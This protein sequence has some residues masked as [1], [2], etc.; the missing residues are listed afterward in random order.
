MADNGQLKRR[1]KKI[2]DQLQNQKNT[3]PEK[4]ALFNRI[5]IKQNQETVTEL[6][7]KDLESQARSQGVAPEQ[8][9]SNGT[10]DAGVD[11]GVSDLSEA[12]QY[13]SEPVQEDDEEEEQSSNIQDR[14]D[15]AQD[16][17]SNQRKRQSQKQQD[18]KLKQQKA[19]DKPKPKTAPKKP[20]VRPTPKPPVASRLSGISRFARGIATVG[21]GLVA[22]FSTPAGWVTLAIILV[23]LIVFGLLLA[24]GAGGK[25]K[26]ISSFGGSQFLPLDLSREEDKAILAQVQSLADPNQ[27][28]PVIEVVAPA[29]VDDLIQLQATDDGDEKYLLDRRIPQTLNYLANEGWNKI[30]IGLLKTNGPDF[31][32]RIDQRSNGNGEENTAYSA[33]GLGQAMGIVAIGKTSPGLTKCLGLDEPIP[34]QIAW[35]EM[36]SENYLRP[37]YEELQV[38]LTYLFEYGQRDWSIAGNSEGVR[39]FSTET[40]QYLNDVKG[41]LVELQTTFNANGSTNLNTVKYAQQAS[42]SLANVNIE[43]AVE[44]WKDLRQGMMMTYTMMRARNIRGWEGSTSNG[45]KLWKAAEAINNQR[46]LE[47][48]LLMM[49]TVLAQPERNGKPGFNGDIVPKQ[50][51]VWSP[52]DDI[53][54]GLPDTDVWPSG[55]T[56]ID[57]GGVGYSNRGKDGIVGFEDAHF[58]YNATDNGVLSKKTTVFLKQADGSRF[59]DMVPDLFQEKNPGQAEFNLL[60]DAQYQ[61]EG[62]VT[63]KSFIQIGF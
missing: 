15:R 33:F 45:C 9:E 11:R 14:L 51:I 35:Q 5:K 59:Y 55:I 42:D 22:F 13:I 21:R 18:R 52:E 23:L 19:A 31:T 6:E 28:D 32:Q 40:I 20:A 44:G 26:A 48:D 61:T 60:W 41:V 37:R 34:V 29:S 57:A 58:L 49:P 3:S 38:K 24:F 7:V 4:R 36:M 50:I 10:V 53:D 8:N 46:K 25:N 17:L 56:S 47:V 39:G 54:N 12:D 16:E 30:I 1:L 62:R 27:Q 43:D 63:Y 2:A